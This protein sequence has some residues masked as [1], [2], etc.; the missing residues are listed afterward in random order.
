M[1]WILDML[2]GAPKRSQEVEATKP[3]QLRETLHTV[4]ETLTKMQKQQ[5]PPSPT[6]VIRSITEDS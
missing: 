2:F 5:A 1:S 6:I 4:D 3:P